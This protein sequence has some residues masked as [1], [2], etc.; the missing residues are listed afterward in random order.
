MPYLQDYHK[1]LPCAV[2]NGFLFSFLAKIGLKP[3]IINT[4]ENT[5]YKMKKRGCYILFHKSE[6]S[7]WTYHEIA[8]HDG[9]LKND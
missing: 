6:N 5:L 1:H 7:E 9:D 3:H 8:I 4:A 2:H